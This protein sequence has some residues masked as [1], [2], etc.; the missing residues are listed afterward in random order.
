MLS[1]L[2]DAQTKPI[3]VEV[4]V[5]VA[6]YSLVSEFV[7]LDG[8]FL[9]R[10]PTPSCYPA[11]RRVVQPEVVCITDTGDLTEKPFASELFRFDMVNT[12]YSS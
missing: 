12:W 2:D 10:E 1:A 7:S 11:T 6:A 3:N 8:H 5:V 4:E 9:P